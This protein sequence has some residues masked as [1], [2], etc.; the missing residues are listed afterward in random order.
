[1][2]VHTLH[3]MHSHKFPSQILKKSRPLWPRMMGDSVGVKE[4]CLILQKCALLKTDCGCLSMW[5]DLLK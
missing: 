4:I 1:M 2:S 5:G 3:C